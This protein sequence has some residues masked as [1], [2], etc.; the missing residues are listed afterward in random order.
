MKLETLV[1]EVKYFQND[2][3]LNICVYE[4]VVWYFEDRE[5]T[6]NTDGSEED[7]YNGRGKTYSF[8]CRGYVESEDGYMVFY[9]TDNGCGT[10][11]TVI[12]KVSDRVR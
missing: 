5:L 1:R 7:L 4:D 11:D 12:V 10:K 3:D 2:I 9:D 8:D 6:I